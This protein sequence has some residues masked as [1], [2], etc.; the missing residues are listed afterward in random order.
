MAKERVERKEQEL[1][2][3][4]EREKKNLTEIVDQHIEEP[5]IERT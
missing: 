2:E 5:R 3:T 4:I 1:Q